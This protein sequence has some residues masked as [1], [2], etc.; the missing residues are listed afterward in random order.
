MTTQLSG[1]A[2]I[3]FIAIGFTTFVLLFIFGKRQIMR[4]ALKSRRAPHF[5]IASD[6]PKHLRKE[7]ERRLD[8]VKDIKSDPLLLRQEI[9]PGS[10]VLPHVYRMKAVDSLKIL[11]QQIVRVTDESKKRPAGQDVRF[12]LQRLA[13]DSAPLD[14]CDPRILNSFIE[15]YQHARHDPQPYGVN[16]FKNHV[17]YL[18]HLMEVLQRK[19]KRDA[20]DNKED[21]ECRPAPP[22]SSLM[23]SVKDK[24]N[25][26]NRRNVFVIN[27]SNSSARVSLSPSDQ[28]RENSGSSPG[29]RKITSESAV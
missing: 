6:A 22:A 5:P 20:M 9:P 4:F 23:S 3:I 27:D 24:E 14:G 1:V 21:R 10:D 28:N 26:L 12:Y 29:S 8:A 19:G 2:I 15:S 18:N 7:I 25:G 11:E 16:E 13:R 17:I